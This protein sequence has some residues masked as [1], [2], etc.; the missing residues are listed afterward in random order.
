[1]I[2]KGH[3]ARAN[4]S[5]I[6]NRALLSRVLSGVVKRF[7]QFGCA[8]HVCDAFEVIC[9]RRETDFDLCKADARARPGDESDLTGEIITKAHL[10]EVLFFH[11]NA[12]RIPSKCGSLIRRNPCLFD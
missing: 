7:R 11:F 4:A 5:N 2:Q 3:D 10:F 1:M 8:E 9:H 6:Q 12:R